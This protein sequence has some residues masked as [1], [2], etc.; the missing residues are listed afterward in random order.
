MFGVVEAADIEQ[1][2]LSDET[3]SVIHTKHTAKLH[4]TKSLSFF[5][6]C[7]GHKHDADGHRECAGG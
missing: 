5:S 7:L 6:S 4:I 3:V 2:S 1:G